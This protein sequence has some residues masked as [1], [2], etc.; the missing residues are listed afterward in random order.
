[1]LVKR[2][3]GPS[4]SRARYKLSK[5]WVVIIAISGFVAALVRDELRPR[6]FFFLYV[7]GFL[8]AGILLVIYGRKRSSRLKSFC[9]W[10]SAPTIGCAFSMATFDL[11]SGQLFIPYIV[12]M[13]T[14]GTL[15]LR[16]AHKE[17][18]RLARE[19]SERPSPP[20]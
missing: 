15:F 2:K 13:A 16:Y 5:R 9:F 1:M 17:R 14:I 6:P 10:A 11:I 12:I 19:E 3:Y 8:L 18:T 4:G 20:Q 7:S